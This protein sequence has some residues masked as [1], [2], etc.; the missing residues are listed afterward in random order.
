M[1]TNSPWGYVDYAKRLCDGVVD[2]NTPSHGGLRVDRVWA[3]KNLTEQAR[4]YASDEDRKYFWFEEDC[5]W[6]IVIFEHPELARDEKQFQ[7]AKQILC[8][9]EFGYLF[10]RGLKNMINV[11]RLKDM[12]EMEKQFHSPQLAN[13]QKIYTELTQN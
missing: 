11:D 12:I 8:Y 4:K 1:S 5:N 7:D 10:D 6:T 3:E 2:V 9:W 13:Y